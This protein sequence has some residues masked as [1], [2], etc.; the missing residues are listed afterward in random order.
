[1]SKPEQHHKECE[2]K[3]ESGVVWFRD[4]FGLIV[5]IIVST[6]CRILIVVKIMLGDIRWHYINTDH[7]IEFNVIVI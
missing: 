2:V 1:M 6:F 4:I 3:K 7:D 5:N